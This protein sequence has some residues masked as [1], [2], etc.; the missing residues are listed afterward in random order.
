MKKKKKNTVFFFSHVQ[1]EP[2][3]EIRSVHSYIIIV[4]SIFVFIILL[5]EFHSPAIR[6]Q[7]I[8]IIIYS[9]LKITRFPSPVVCMY[10]PHNNRNIIFLNVIR[11]IANYRDG[12]NERSISNI[13]IV[14]FTFIFL[15]R[16]LY[17]M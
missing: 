17:V 9:F 2:I 7:I 10:A 16:K 14:H 4:Y 13:I 15:N 8:R 3:M 12:M 6:V 1:N 5:F 11:Y